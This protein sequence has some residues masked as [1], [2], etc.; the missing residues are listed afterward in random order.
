MLIYRISLDGNPIRTIRRTLLSQSTMELK[1][2]LRTRGPPLAGQE[3]AS[4]RGQS[5][6]VGARAGGEQTFID[7]SV[8]NRLRNIE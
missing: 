8:V 4:D 3:A 5:Y 6:V 2:Y 1:T 7:A